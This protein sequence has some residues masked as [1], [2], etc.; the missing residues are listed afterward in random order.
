[1]FL[2]SYKNI[3]FAHLKT[4]LKN[5]F[6][7]IIFDKLENLPYNWD[8]LAVDN[9]FLSTNYLQ[10]LQESAPLNMQ[11]FYIGVFSN[12]ELVGIAIAQFLDGNQMKTFGSRDKCV[13][14]FVRNFFFKNFSSQVLFIGN[15]MLT[16]Q[17]AYSFSASTIKI[18]ALCELKKAS[19]ELEQKIKSEEGTLH[20]TSFKDFTAQDEQLFEAVDFSAF[21]QF[22]IQPNMVFEIKEHWQSMDDYVNALT[23]KY[24]DQYKRAR[25]KATAIEKRKLTF[26]E[27][28]ASENVIFDLYLHVA[29]N[30]PFNTFLL[31]RNHFSSLKRNLGI[32]FLFYGYFLDG[33][34]IGFNTLIKNG[35]AMDTYFLGYDNEMQ[36]EK[37]LYL[38]MLYDMIG[39][40]IKKKFKKI[41]FGRTAL[42][43][44]SSV[45]AVPQSMFGYIK[46]SNPILQWQMPR[47][48]NSLQ[49]KV[50]WNTR[51]PFKENE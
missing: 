8:D 15:N 46:H 25:K 49:P 44:K 24:R 1:M 19:Q 47:I 2:G 18:D 36:R 28:L 22:N 5:N 23:K 29:E 30:A 13:K 51:N 10:V 16:G 17:N 48:F 4:H 14:T 39:Y 7:H 40:S 21:Y 6:H 20:L 43:I 34:L 38:N 27:I 32:D 35:A 9:I 12:A 37:M 26:E 11:C 33:Q 42:E 31:Q 41:I 45:G 50:D 3:T